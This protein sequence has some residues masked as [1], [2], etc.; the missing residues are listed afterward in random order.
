M[1]THALFGQ[2]RE[3]W[4][5][6]TLFGLP[7]QF[8]QL[9]HGLAF[10]FLISSPYRH[11][12]GTAVLQST[13]LSL[14]PLSAPLPVLSPGYLSHSYPFPVNCVTHHSSVLAGSTRNILLSSEEKRKTL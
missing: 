5:D 9:R 13:P 8:F 7:H 14:P 11:V 12:V 1:L 10:V 3:S 6:K 4:E 2:L